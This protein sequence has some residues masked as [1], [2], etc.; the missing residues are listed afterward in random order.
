[1]SLLLQYPIIYL[2]SSGATNRET[3]PASEEFAAL[4]NLVAAAVAA[5]VSLIQLREK[6]LTARTLHELTQ[7]AAQ[8][9][10]KGQTRLLINDRSDIAKAAGAD[11]VHLTTYSLP[12]DVIR[13]TFGD[14]FL[15]GVSTHSVA[16]ARAARDNG[17]NFVVWGPV[18]ATDSKA[19]YGEPQGV[20]ELARVVQQLAPF[21]VVA[22]GGITV[23][24]IDEC[25]NAG[26]SGI[27]GIGLFHNENDLAQIVSRIREPFRK[28]EKQRSI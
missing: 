24:N 18:F 10:R 2:I 15:I 19:G 26:A 12:A 27:A 7:R 8:L 4:L 3:T 13:K 11:G 1:M 28:N 21:P 20:D 5:K 6:H 25:L 22:L 23:N 9:T 17:A 14:D 16:E